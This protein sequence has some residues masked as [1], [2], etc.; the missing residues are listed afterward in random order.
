MEFQSFNVEKENKIATVSINRAEKANSLDVEAW[1]EMKQVFETL[2]E[3]KEVRVI[4]LRGEGKHFCAGM[5]LASL[6]TI[7]NN[8]SEK[9]QAKQRLKIR[10]FIKDIQDCISA[11]EA[12]KKPVIAAIQKACVGGGINI[13]TACDMRYCTD[14]TFF[15]IK[16][17]DLG[18]VA[19]IGVLQRLPTIINPGYV[20][21]LAY[22]GRN[23]NGQEAKRL[24]LV[25]D[26]FSEYQDMMTHV[27]GVAKDIASK[28]P[29]VTRGIKE[30]LLYK[31]DHSVADAMNYIS[32]WN[33]G[34][35]LSE[36]LNI[37]MMAYMQKTAPVF[38]D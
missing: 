37:A 3:D 33:A 12:C 6:M 26:S 7:P 28:S 32:T 16:E 36:D 35:L 25:T 13:V 2:A 38:E 24:G 9:C 4:I 8:G 30:M 14:D 34:L 5:D 27:I 21:E 11:I 1:H 29:L 18:I 17:V 31:R 23:F 19:D 22:T 10:K 20:A 15:S